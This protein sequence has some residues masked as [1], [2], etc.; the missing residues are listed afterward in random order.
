MVDLAAEDNAADVKVLSLTKAVLSAGVD[1]I[2]KKALATP[3]ALSGASAISFVVNG[4]TYRLAAKG[5]VALA[6]D[7]VTGADDLQTLI[8][9]GN[10]AYEAFMVMNR[11]LTYKADGSLNAMSYEKYTDVETAVKLIS[12][13]ELVMVKD[14]FADAIAN[15]YTANT[16]TAGQ[17]ETCT[18]WVLGATAIGGYTGNTIRAYAPQILAN[19]GVSIANI[20]RGARI[21]ANKTAAK[22]YEGPSAGNING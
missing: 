20:E 11:A 2:S 4:V 3:V 6:T 8:D 18:E 14:V 1:A 15:A 7:A 10:N 17:K 9:A 19:G 22:I 12:A 16:I 5:N 21:T 13:A